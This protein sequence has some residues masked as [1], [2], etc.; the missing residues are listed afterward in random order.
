MAGAALLLLAL[1]AI[2]LVLLA[3]DRHD[4]EEGTVTIPAPRAEDQNDLP[5]AAN[6]KENA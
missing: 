2:V 6:E 1:I 5:V 3:P 4:D